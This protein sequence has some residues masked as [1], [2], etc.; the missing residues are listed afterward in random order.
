MRNLLE[1]FGAYGT[2]MDT[3]AETQVDEALGAR[4][5]AILCV[6]EAQR[7]RIVTRTELA[8]AAGLPVA[9]RRIDV[10]L[11]NVRRHVGSESLV[12]VRSRGWMLPG[13]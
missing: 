2:A 13:T 10:H 11:V 7:G 8:R 12:N 5:Q 6:L 3:S 4:E 1:T 9:S